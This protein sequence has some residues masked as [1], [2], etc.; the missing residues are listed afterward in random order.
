MTRSW[1]GTCNNTTKQYPRESLKVM[2]INIES[3]LRSKFAE[4]LIVFW[5]IVYRKPI[6]GSMQ[7]GRERS[8]MAMP[9]FSVLFALIVAKIFL[10]STTLATVSGRLLLGIV[11]SD[12]R[13]IVHNANACL[14]DYLGYYFDGHHL[15]WN[16][17]TSLII[18]P[19]QI[20]KAMFH[21]FGSKSSTDK[22]TFVFF[23]PLE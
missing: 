2:A 3:C 19:H 8:I 13:C 21:N 16:H 11:L 12:H 17:R 1:G 18:F 14:W 22:E 10:K 4:K 5:I 9:L 7:M 20:A 6:Q 15:F 23:K